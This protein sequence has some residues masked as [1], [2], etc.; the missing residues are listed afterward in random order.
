VKK[1]VP[2]L[3]AISVGLAIASSCFPLLATTVASLG[4]WSLVAIVGSGALVWLVSRAYAELAGIY[5]T[6]AGVRTYVARAYGERRGLWLALLYLLLVVGLGASEAFI[7]S[8]VLHAIFPGLAPLSVCLGFVGACALANVLGI[9]TAGKLQAVL[10]YGLVGGLLVLALAALGGAAPAPVPAP[11]GLGPLASGLAGAVFLFVG[12]EWVVSAVEEVDPEARALP[13]AMSWSLGLLAATYALLALAFGGLGR[14]ALATVTPHLLLGASLGRVGLY[15][16]AALST[17]ATIT[18]FNGGILGSSRLCYALAREGVLPR[19][20]ATLSMRFLTPWVAIVAVSVLT[21]AGALLVSTT[22][23]VKVPILA[24]AAIECA[25]Y[26]AVSL[27]FARLRVSAPLRERPYRAP[28]GPLAAR[29]LAVVFGALSLA[30]VLGAGELALPVALALGAAA[31]VTGLVAWNTKRPRPST[32][33][34]TG[35]E[36]AHA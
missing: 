25:V 34:T 10:A 9:E 23:A 8:Q 6:A 30:C 21:G 14:A 1:P 11:I 26:A 36:V 27:S 2:I 22:G 13:R 17:A 18:C 3:A 28:F 4:S 20:L 29:A 31:S 35:L 19:P 12:F 15:A 7:L 33:L 5:P 32:E 24:G 16:A